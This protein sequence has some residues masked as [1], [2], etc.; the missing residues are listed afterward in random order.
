MAKNT[1][2]GG[3]GADRVF[4]KVLTD[5]AGEL[6]DCFGVSALQRR[7]QGDLAIEDFN[8]PPAKLCNARLLTA[9]QR[10][11]AVGHEAKPQEKADLLS[12]VPRSGK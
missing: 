1:E 7:P 12:P 3:L 10:D 9:K 4:A 6:G 2:F 11:A 8:R 5:Q